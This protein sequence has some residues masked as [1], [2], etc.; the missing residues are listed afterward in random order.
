MLKSS[1]HLLSSLHVPLKPS[2]ASALLY[3]FLQISSLQAPGKVHFIPL[4]LHHAYVSVSNSGLIGVTS[5]AESWL[6]RVLSME[7]T[8]FA[9]TFLYLPTKPVSSLLRG[10]GWGLHILACTSVMLPAFRASLTLS[11]FLREEHTYVVCTYEVFFPSSWSIECYIT[12]HS[13]W[14]SFRMCYF[15]FVG[16]SGRESLCRQAKREKGK[17]KSKKKKNRGINIWEEGI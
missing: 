9:S 8:C 11:F 15:G 1:A 3:F 12:F 13:P 17:E 5:L 16:G 2:P 14:C 7:N 6:S 10:G 4:Y